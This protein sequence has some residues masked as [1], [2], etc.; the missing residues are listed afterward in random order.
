VNVV[1]SKIVPT[2]F[3]H[4]TLA[5]IR[6]FPVE[7]YEN[8]GF[9]SQMTLESY[10]KAYLLS[11]GTRGKEFASKIFPDDA[12]AVVVKREPNDAPA[13]VVKRE[14]TT[15][16]APTPTSAVKRDNAPVARFV[17]KRERLN[18]SPPV[19]S[20]DAT[21]T[22]MKRDRPKPSPRTG[23]SPPPLVLAKTPKSG[24]LNVSS[25]VQTP[26]TMTPASSSSSVVSHKSRSRVFTVDD[27]DNDAA[28]FDPIVESSNDDDLNDED[29]IILED[30]GLPEKKPT[31]PKKSKIGDA[32]VINEKTGGDEILFLHLTVDERDRLI[33]SFEL[34]LNLLRNI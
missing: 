11:M 21:V 17:G 29:A 23:A 34:A 14:R 30:M 24:G 9:E 13:A 18:P 26:A 3:A 7:D 10:V 16:R 27:N 12:A 33:A 22:G 15:T 31:P 28:P 25:R 8:F 5:Q 20:Y 6:C 32:P 19:R 4:I 2:I 1:L